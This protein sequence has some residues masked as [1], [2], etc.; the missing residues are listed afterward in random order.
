MVRLYTRSWPFGNKESF[1]IFFPPNYI[2]QLNQSHK[3][4]LYQSIRSWKAFYYFKLTMK[5][6]EIHP[7]AFLLERNEF[8]LL[9]ENAYVTQ[10]CLRAETSPHFKSLKISITVHFSGLNH[11]ILFL[12]SPEITLKFTRKP[13][14]GRH[15]DLL[16]TQWH[17]RSHLKYLRTFTG[18]SFMALF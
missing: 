18:H 13:L 11:S 12:P 1:V 9:G 4:I 8:W 10:F 3:L 6:S 7:F 15:S 5:L 2:T 16:R 14:N 17:R